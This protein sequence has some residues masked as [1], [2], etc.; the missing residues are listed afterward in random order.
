MAAHI[1]DESIS[2]AEP[3]AVVEEALL[4]A[5]VVVDG[6]AATPASIFGSR[7]EARHYRVGSSQGRDM[8]GGA[9]YLHVH[10]FVRRFQEI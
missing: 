8:R 7:S 4:V 5:A 3:V 10:H 1:D 2:E 6:G 9:V